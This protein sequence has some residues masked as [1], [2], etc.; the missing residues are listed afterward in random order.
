MWPRVS[1]RHR[2]CWSLLSVCFGS[3]LLIG[4]ALGLSSAT[5]ASGSAAAVDAGS[6]Q[7]PASAAPPSA[8]PTPGV[9]AARP[10]APTGYSWL[11][12]SQGQTTLLMPDGWHATTDADGDQPTL[13]VSKEPA[14]VVGH[15]H[16]GLSLRVLRD[17]TQQAGMRPSQFAE[18]A[19]AQ[20]VASSEAI[21]RWSGRHASGAVTYSYR[22]RDAAA[23]PMLIAQAYF[24]ADDQGDIL[25][26]LVFS[27]PESEWE[28]AWAIGERIVAQLIAQ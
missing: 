2:P 13:Y 6:P 3:G 7:V 12:F 19:L 20:G 11:E 28:R 14:V 23:T 26:V 16:T 8:L 27:A 5:G 17:L 4:S 1:R 15:F 9:R 25:R 21:G 18:R 10:P 22:Y 24:L